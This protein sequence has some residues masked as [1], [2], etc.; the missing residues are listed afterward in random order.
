V[1]ALVIADEE[2]VHFDRELRADVLISCGDVS[3]TFIMRVAEMTLC[4]TIFAVK[5]NHDEGSDFTPPIKDLHLHVHEFRGLR[6]GGF[7]GAWKYK[8]RGHFLYEQSE[9]EMMLNSFPPV[10]IFIAHNSPRLVHEWDDR[11]HIGFKAFNTY[12]ERTKPQVFIHGHQH[13]NAE[14]LFDETRI[15]GVFGQRWIRM[16][17]GRKI[18]EKP[19]RQ[20]A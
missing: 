4:R 17:A 14:S 10:D 18:S 1:R 3:D 15:I 19:P 6:F 20:R 5:G 2:N 16:P 7:N 13:V 12:I 8:P 9:V 11:A